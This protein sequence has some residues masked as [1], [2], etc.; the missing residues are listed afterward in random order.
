MS[1]VSP[2][3]RPLSV[4]DE[5]SEWLV[6]LDDDNVPSEDRAAFERWIAGGPDRRA[7]FDRL[8][9]DWHRFDD[10]QHL[11]GA[12]TT[13]I[14][15]DITVR[16]ASSQPSRARR[17]PALLAAATA[18]AATLIWAVMPASDIR[19]YAT[20]VGTRETLTLP[21]GSTVELNTDSELEVDFSGDER[22]LELTRGEAFFQVAH[23]RTRP[24]IVTSDGTAVRAVGTAFNVRR[25]AGDVEVIVTQGRVEVAHRRLPILDQLLPVVQPIAL[26][27]GGRAEVAGREASVVELDGETI[28]RDLAWRRG[29]LAFK[30]EPLETVV[31]ELDRYTDIEVSFADDSIRQL[32]VGGHFPATDV[33]AVLAAMSVAL[34]VRVERIDDRT[35]RLHRA[36][37][38]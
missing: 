7:A 36:E 15:P 37:A 38:R 4:E 35:V 17:R 14:D 10:L 13:P 16:W 21:D 19:T 28:D 26:T 2:F 25:R 1:K 30:D 32:K 5:A 12:T 29:M 18:L 22:R 33:D 23:D 9:R 6:R 24:F 3:E 8:Q 27:A 20:N 31:D 11:R 34:P